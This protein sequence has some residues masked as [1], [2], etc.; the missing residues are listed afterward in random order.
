MAGAA[1]ALHAAASL[2]AELQRCRW[3]AW[4]HER[5][6]ASAWQSS[7]GVCCSRSLTRCLPDMLHH[8]PAFVTCPAQLVVS[9]AVIWRDGQ[10]TGMCTCCPGAEQAFLVWSARQR[11]PGSALSS[12]TAGP[13][14]RL[15]A[16]DV[17]QVNTG[18]PCEPAH[19]LAS[20]RRT[21]HVMQ[22]P[23]S[24]AAISVAS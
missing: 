13:G 7:S 12:L 1:A 10:L 8:Q 21:S 9:V 23:D 4:Q 24:P 15:G 16:V 14:R 17:P 3:G 19:A 2:A 18:A 11:G 5:V 6:R 20:V 22:A